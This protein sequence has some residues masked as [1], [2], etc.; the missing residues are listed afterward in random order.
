MN[1]NRR[2]TPWVALL[3]LALLHPLLASA[4]DGIWLFNRFPGDKVKQKY[5]FEVT[6]TYLDRLRLGSV[7]FFG[8]ASG[9]FVSPHGLLFTNHH[10]ASECIQQLST[11]ENDYMNNGFLAATGADERKC[12][13]LEADVLLSIDDVT[14]QITEGVPAD[15]ASAEAGRVRRANVAR[16]E[17]AC[18]TSPDDRCEVVTLYSG[19]EY[20]LYKYRKYTDIRLVFAPEVGIA[21]F[22]GDPDNFTYP[23]YCLDMTFFRAYVDG[24]P[25]DTPGYLHWSLE[26]V[27]EGDLVFVPGNPGSTGR[28]NTVAQLE[29][30]RD[31][32]YPLVHARLAALIKTLL[33]FSAKS[34]ENKRVAADNLFSQQNS[35]KAYSGYL[36]GLRDAKLMELKRR[37]ES[38]L[39]AAVSRDPKLS[40]AYGAAWDRIAAAYKQFAESY[41]AY[42]LLESAAGRGS[43]LFRIARDVVRLSEERGKPND[44]R[45]RDYRDSALPGVEGSLYATIPISPAMEMAVIEDYLTFLQQSLGAGDATVKA[46]LDGRSPAQAARDFVTSSK[47]ADVAERKRLAASADA[48]KS[49]N[50]GMV[51]LALLLDSRA[52]ELRKRYEDTLETVVNGEGGSVARAR[53]AVLGA[54][55]YPD[56]TFTPRVSYGPVKG[57]RNEAGKDVP[58]TT[59]FE[60]LYR[61][62]TGKDPF[63]LPARWV[64]SKPKLN[65]AMPFNFVTTADTH[66][67]SSGSPTVNTKGEIVG[68]L[69]DGNLESLPDRFVYTDERARSVHVSI[70]GI[71]EALRRVYRADA[72]L[73]ELGVK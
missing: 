9:S 6:G 59:T 45:L 32:S 62:A 53:F 73:A 29:Y 55:A 36:L 40:S 2:R 13:D 5:G 21:A 48:V 4:D 49:S 50:D 57:Y 70:Q 25:A 69:F 11:K 51:R 64:K 66:G 58:F 16:I 31:V 60:G 12:P 61:R 8:V 20:H 38:D 10:V 1:G 23:R 65:L 30:F 27:K 18:T 56:A 19:G 41:K 33:A 26:G 24:K 71:V 22:G 46:I 63:R 15:S 39:R 47:L 17:K 54:S 68:I 3:T 35:Y 42:F 67:G 52:R 14:P 28:L 72:L 37:E 7:R 43:D 34:A 44:Q